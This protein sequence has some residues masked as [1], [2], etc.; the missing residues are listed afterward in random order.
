M[1]D[2]P[3]NTP[4]GVAFLEA[5]Q[6]MGYDIRDI[7]GEK[8]TG[9]ALWQFTMRRGSRCSTAK[10]FLRPVRLR[11]NLHITM[12]THVTKIHI[13]PVTK[14]AHSVEMVRNGRKHLVRARKEV[15]LSAGAVNSPQLL[16][17]S[18]IGPAEHLRKVGVDVVHDS[19]GERS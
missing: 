15:V 1:Q 10:A 19:P 12:W 7:N 11:P 4:I 9:F 18:G 16:M 17:L 8:Q 2:A 5:A 13:D 14:R 3:Y 6:E